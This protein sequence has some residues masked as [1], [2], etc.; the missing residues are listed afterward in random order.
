MAK[1]T[2]TGPLREELVKVPAEKTKRPYVQGHKEAAGRGVAVEN[3]TPVPIKV[4][5]NLGTSDT[6]KGE[7][8]IEG[9]CDEEDDS[10]SDDS[11]D[12]VDED[13]LAAL[14]VRPGL[15]SWLE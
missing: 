7:E 13:D 12:E 15:H 1:E 5:G 10:Y 14:D 6:R 11:N 4:S 3:R 8:S 9:G 2:D